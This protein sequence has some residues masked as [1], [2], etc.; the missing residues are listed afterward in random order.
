MNWKPIL[1]SKK[2]KFTG[3]AGVQTESKQSA[4]S[5]SGFTL[6]ELLLYMG[7][8]SALMMVILEIF[9]TTLEVESRAWSDSV[10]SQDGQYILARL[11]YDIRRADQILEPV[12]FG[13]PA[14]TLRL[15]V[16]GAEVS[17]QLTGEE[18]TITDS[19][20]TYQLHSP[21]T[22]IANLS[23][24]KLGDAQELITVET[25]FEIKSPDEQMWGKSQQFETV[26]GVRN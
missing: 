23:F 22:N 8:F 1:F 4:K 10:V 24:T 5:R 16:D 25:D 18:L 14:Q 2:N 13:S 9:I 15:D 11:T 3:T 6:V 12:D 21:A 20:G 26:A 19:T 17:Y 7:L